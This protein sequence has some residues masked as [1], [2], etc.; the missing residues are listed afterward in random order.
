[1]NQQ[2]FRTLFR[3]RMLIILLLILQ[4]GFLLYLITSGSRLS[5]II[6]NLLTVLSALIALHIIAKRDNG[7]YKTTWVFLILL[8]P[9]FGGLL[10]LLFL[11]QSPTRK[12]EMQLKK[13]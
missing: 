8:F 7:A 2:W 4:A 10:Y 11:F 3:R 13:T 12:M 1:M 5:H 6:S 9:V